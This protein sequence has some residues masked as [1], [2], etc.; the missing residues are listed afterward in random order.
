MRLNVKNVCESKLDSPAGGNLQGE[1][2]VHVVVVVQRIVE[3]L[4]FTACASWTI[5]TIASTE[6]IIIQNTIREA[7]ALST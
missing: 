5:T 3:G 6:K 1:G 4:Q 2:D 7:N